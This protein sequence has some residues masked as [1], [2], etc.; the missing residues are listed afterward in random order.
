M[1]LDTRV[2]KQPSVH[3]GCLVRGQV[4][5]DH[6]DGQARLGLA[7]DLIQE[8]PEVHGPVLGGQLADDFPGG[9]VQRGEQVDGTVPDVVMAAPLGGSGDHRQHRRGPFQGLDLRLLI[10]GEDRRAFGRRQ[11]EPDDV[12]DLVDEQ[13]VRG[14]LEVLG[15]PGLQAECPP[16]AVHG[17]RRDP[18]LPGQFPLGPVRGALGGLLQGAHHHLLYLGISDGARHPRT[19]VIGQPVQPAGQE[20]GPPLR[21][22]APVDSQPRRD[23]GIAVALGARQHDPCPQRQALCGLAPLRPVLQRPPLSIGQ[24]Q[25]L[26]P[27]ITHATSRPPAK[28]AVTTRLEPETKHDS[29]GDEAT[30]DRDT[31][32]R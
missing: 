5:A 26:Q 7:V 19:G 13:R 23:R 30:Q 8:V 32:H 20:P 2:G 27:V 29:R 28:G 1:Q 10:H 16:D 6:V 4:V 15:P 17:G 11:V 24:R 12:T 18:G 25:R 22:C 3:R 31:S 14:D 21:D 9:G